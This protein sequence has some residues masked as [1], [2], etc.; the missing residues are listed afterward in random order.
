MIGGFSSLEENRG[1]CV[2]AT[3]SFGRLE[4]SIYSDLDLFLIHEERTDPLSKIGARLLT[5][6]LIRATRELEFPEFSGDGEFL[7]VH[8]VD[9]ILSQMGSPDDDYENWFTARLLLLLESR[10]VHDDMVYQRVVKRIVDSYYRDFADHM[11]GFQPVFLL[12]DIIRFWKTLCLNYERK[13]NDPRRAKEDAD[14]IRTKNLKLK[15]SRLLT[16]FSAV[17]PLI[18]KGDVLSP[19]GVAQLVAVPPIERL[20]LAAETGGV[21]QTFSEIEDHYAWFLSVTER[22]EEDLIDF[23][24]S[25]ENRRLASKHG[26]AFG[27]AVYNLMS[28][29]ADPER[30]RYATV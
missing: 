19:D 1:L 2:Y 24:R 21:Q 18:Q 5:A 8:P 11:V 30:L 3:G 9:N 12:N 15:F 28:Q 25:E 4:A 14:K 16:C 27:A 23:L 17:V 10:S 20:R 29:V 13:R 6:D 7:E 26:N 22:S